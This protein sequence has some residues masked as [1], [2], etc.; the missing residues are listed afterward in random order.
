MNGEQVSVNHIEGGWMM[1]G[2][3]SESQAE[4]GGNFVKSLVKEAETKISL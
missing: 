1:L 4:N 3:I 2:R